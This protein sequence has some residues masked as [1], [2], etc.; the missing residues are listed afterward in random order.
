MRHGDINVYNCDALVP[1]ACRVGAWT[2]ACEFA[3]FAFVTFRIVNYLRVS[4]W[5]HNCMGM[6]LFPPLS[7]WISYLLTSLFVCSR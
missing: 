2:I 6:S 5:L 7:F 3:S 4:P 1:Q